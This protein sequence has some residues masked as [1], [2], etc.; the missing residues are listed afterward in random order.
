MTLVGVIAATWKLSSQITRI[1]TQLT[2]HL[3][4]HEFFEKLLFEKMC[5][6]GHDDG[7]DDL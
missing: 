7:G 2:N 5:Q 4:H 1:E 6:K 3:R